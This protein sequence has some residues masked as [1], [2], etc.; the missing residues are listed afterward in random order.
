MRLNKVISGG[1]TGADRAGLECAKALGLATGGTAPKGYRT[2]N[3]T[4]VSLKDFGLTESVDTSYVPR[5]RANAKNS[6]VTLWFGKTTSPGY[7]CTKKACKDWGKVMIDNPSPDRAVELADTY[8][9]WNIAGNRE[10]TNPT[11][12]ELVKD[13]FNALKEHK[14]QVWAYG[15]GPDTLAGN[16]D[17]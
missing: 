11:V 5:T 12:V 3:G 10:S 14:R 7:Y 4:D 17:L 9:S 6:D 15:S 13:F 8:D 1:Q 16:E 2:E